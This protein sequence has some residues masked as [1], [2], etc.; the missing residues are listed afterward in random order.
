MA[1]KV[2]I[3]QHIAVFG[4]LCG[5]GSILAFGTAKTFGSSEEDKEKLLR[6]RYDHL[7][8]AN[9]KSR[10]DFQVS[11]NK[12]KEG[13]GT[14]DED[15][16]FKDILKGGKGEKRRYSRNLEAVMKANSEKASTEKK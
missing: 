16:E 11:F 15:T 14:M 6:S 1:P 9:T 12:L 13:R 5:V 8:K 3:G 10:K 2:K 4:T 7:I